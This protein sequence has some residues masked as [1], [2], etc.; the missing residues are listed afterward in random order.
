MTILQRLLCLLAGLLLIGC[1]AEAPLPSSAEARQQVIEELS[2]TVNQAL[3]NQVATAEELPDSPMACQ[4]WWAVNT[5]LIW[6]YV[7]TIDL[8]NSADIDTIIQTTHDYWTDQRFHVKGRSLNTDPALHASDEAG[9]N[10]EL[11]FDAS[12]TQAILTGS[13]P[14]LP[15]PSADS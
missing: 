14:C 3:G 11:Q 7:I 6:G 10:Y 4:P 15:R 13:T 12:H 5:G 1:G 8:E 2:R 9:N